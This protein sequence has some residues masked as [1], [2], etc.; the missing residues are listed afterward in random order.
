MRRRE[1]GSQDTDTHR[2]SCGAKG[3]ESIGAADNRDFLCE[4]RQKGHA[5]RGEGGERVLNKLLKA[6]ILLYE[7]ITLFVN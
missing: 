6:S 4:R 3:E 5:R 1:R 2:A 7:L